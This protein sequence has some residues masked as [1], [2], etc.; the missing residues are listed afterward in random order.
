MLA[1]V[2]EYALERLEASGEWPRV[3]ERFVRFLLTLV[4]TAEPHLYG[5]ERDTWLEHLR[6]EDVNLGAALAW[7]KENRG[8]VEIGL[9]LAGALSFFWFQ[10]GYHREGLSWLEAMLART[11]ETDRS[12]ARAKALY[13]V[14]L[15]SWKQAMAEAGARHAE[16][17]L[18]IFRER[19]DPLWSGR[20]ELILAISQMSQGH[21]EAARPLLDECLS[22]FRDTKSSWGEAYALAFLG[23]GNEIRGN[24]VDA[25]SYY[26]EGVRRFQENH[27]LIDGS[28]AL[29]VL[30]ATRASMRD[31]EAVPSYFE[32]L[33]RL[34]PQ[35]SNRW[36][37][38]RFL[39]SAGFNF[40]YSYRLY[41]T[42]K[43][44]YQGSLVLWREMPC[45]QADRRAARVERL[46]NGMGIVRGL[47]GLAEIAAIQLQGARSGWLFGAADHLTPSSGFHREVLNERAARIHERFD[48]ATRATFDAAWA[49]GKTATLEQ[50]IEK[51]LQRATSAT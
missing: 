1:T 46:E 16:V 37:V 43:L 36:L 29:G 8:T 30:A 33:Q 4:E 38:G 28:V 14:G 18:S 44:L 23:I 31:Q 21:F 9:R 17:A 12:H 24:R 40:Q 13:G 45:S 19:G 6:S 22:I 15:L 11:A 42:A 39:L 2:R 25:L 51:A 32:E 27:D 49:E 47:I 34:V 50:T 3:Q 48:A 35:T 5:P 20:A 26:Q 10:T 41:E 7:S